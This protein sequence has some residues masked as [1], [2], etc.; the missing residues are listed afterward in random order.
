MH[1]L[2]RRVFLF[3]RWSRELLVVKYTKP[4]LSLEDQADLLLKR[5]MVGDR[6][7]MI[8]R[9]SAVSYYRLSGY[10]F[11]RKLADDSFEPVTR[12]DVAWEQYIFDR[13]LRLLLMDV[14]ERVEVGPRTQFSFH[15]AQAHG[16]FG[17]A[18]EATALP[19]LPPDKRRA[20]LLRISDEVERSKEQFVLHFAQ[21]CGDSHDHL[22]IW[23]ATEIMSFGCVLSLWQASSKIVKNRVAATFGV[24]DE[25]LRTWFWTLNEVRNIC[26]HHG[27]L[28]NRDLGNKPTIPHAKHHP[29]WHAPVAIPSHRVFAALTICAYSLA[30]LA[31]SSH[32]QERVRKLLNEH[33]KI[34]TKN[35]GFPD[36]WLKS[37]LWQG[38]ANAA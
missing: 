3:V 11:H 5:G 7:K 2:S 24:S 36:E 19:K 15:H 8:R 29:D 32:W 34:P 23:M 13:K 17:Y 38:A 35:I 28:W 26:A 14:I 31:P 33:P 1:A 10:W 16:A 18:T 27:R 20:L 22:P 6:A 21:K 9:L 25:V 30:R 4:A 37:P 12:F